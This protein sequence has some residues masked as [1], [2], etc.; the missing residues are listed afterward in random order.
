MPQTFVDRLHARTRALGH[1]LCVGLD[2][3]LALLPPLFRRGAMQ[4][5]T[6]ETAQAVRAFCLAVLDCVAARVAVVKPQSALFEAL[7]ADGARV[8]A[9]VVRAA[10]ARGL[11]V[12]LDAKRGDIGSSATGYAAA[13]IDR[14]APLAVD[15]LTVNPWLGLETLEPFL[16]AARA[17]GA[18]IFVLLKTSNPGSADLQDRR[19]LRG[20]RLHRALAKKLAARAETCASASGWSSLGVVVGATHPKAAR[21]LRRA[22]PKSPFLVPGYGAQGASAKDALASFTRAKDGALEGGTIN[23]SRAVLF[24]PRAAAASDAKTWEQA[25]RDAL[26]KGIEEVRAAMVRWE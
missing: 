25:V 8:L 4:P 24:P 1:P 3:H 7:G 15:A 26:D 10:R 23:T 13:Y 5:G 21:A 18:G 2:P 20:P 17:S 6:P 9:D 22:L 19:M 11:L 16:D 14:D 12:I